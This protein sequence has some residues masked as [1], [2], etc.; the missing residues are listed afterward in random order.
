MMQLLS[1]FF[2]PPLWE[3][4]MKAPLRKKK[5][6]EKTVIPPLSAVRV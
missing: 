5:K 1:F 6:Y 4:L 2:Q 3:R